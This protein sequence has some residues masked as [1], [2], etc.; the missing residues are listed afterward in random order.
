MA[1]R[2]DGTRDCCTCLFSE[3]FVDNVSIAFSGQ[4]P[5]LLN[6]HK[7]K[8]TA[9]VGQCCKAAFSEGNPGLWWALQEGGDGFAGITLLGSPLTVSLAQVNHPAGLDR[10]AATSPGALRL[11]MVAACPERVAGKDWVCKG[12]WSRSQP[13]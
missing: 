12:P 3:D 7:P 9:H 6:R 4:E 13:L 5:W 10:N 1:S 8:A 11:C 2:R